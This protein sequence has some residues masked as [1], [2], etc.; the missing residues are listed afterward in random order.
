MVKRIT[1]LPVFLFIAISLYSCRAVTAMFDVEVGDKPQQ[2]EDEFINEPEGIHVEVWQENLDIPWS[3][4]FLPETELALVSERSGRIRLIKDGELQS[5]PYAVIEHVAHRKGQEAGLMGL[6]VHP[7]FPDF[8]YIYVKYTHQDE[9][10]RDNRIIRLK[11]DE[12][13]GTFDEIILKGMPAAGNHNGGRIMFGPDNMLYVG[14]GEIFDRKIAQDMDNL[15]GKILRLMPNGSIPPDNPI[16]GSYVYSL[17]HRNPQG[18]AW[19]PETRDL[20]SSEH[21]PSGEMALFAKDIINLIH[22]GKNYGWPKVVGKVENPKYEDP[23]IMWETATPPSGMTFWE[24]DLFVA[25]LRSRAL[26][27]IEMTHHGNSDYEI[28][29]IERWFSSSPRSGKY[30]RLRDAVVG[31]DGALYVLTSN[32]DG[33]G[34]PQSNDDKVLRITRE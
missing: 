31:P 28:T 23:I 4:V 12:T 15:G 25:T 17:G 30:G 9:D 7:A 24:G 3:L 1:T 22:G 21:G 13:K 19:H 16:S 2:V 33:R 32:T 14:T 5:E 34:D 27:R 8:P 11:H 10:G 26:I 29:A 20:F 18:L 6:A